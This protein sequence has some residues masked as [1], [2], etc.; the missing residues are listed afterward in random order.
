MSNGERQREMRERERWRR[1]G[2]TGS[3]RG[4]KEVTDRQKERWVVSGN[5]WDL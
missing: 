5:V 4:K 1:R 3:E 2:R